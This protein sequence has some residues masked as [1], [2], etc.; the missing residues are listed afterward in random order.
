MEKLKLHSPDLSKANIDKVAELFPQCVSEA[1]DENGAIVRQIDFDLL[2]QELSGGIV[3]GP[4]ER[5]QLT[6]PGKREALLT[7]NAPI[8]KTLRPCREESVDFDTTRNLFIEGDNLDVLKLLQETYLGKVKMIYIDPPYN[9]GNDFLYNDKFSV[10]QSENDLLSSVRNDEGKQTFTTDRLTQN[11]I[12]SGRFH[13]DW[14]SMMYPRLR[15][16]KNVLR[17][18]GVMLISIDDAEVHNLRRLCDEVFGKDNFIAS[19]VWEKGRKN[20]AKLVSV[21]HEYVLVYAKSLARLKELKVIWR[22]EKPGAREI[23]EQYLQLRAEHSEGVQADRAIE[24]GLQA[25]YASLPKSHPSK[26]WSRYKRIDRHGPWRDRDISWP[27]SG[28]PR[29]DVLH[30]DTK[31]PCIVPEAGWRFSSSLEMQRQIKL[32]LVEFRADHTEPPFRK[33]HIRPIQDEIDEPDTDG[34]EESE[35]EESGDEELA[36]Q[37]RGSYFYKQSQVSVKALRKLMGAKIF[38][39]PKDLD[40]IAR[41]VEYVSSGDPEAIVMD[42]FA[43]SGTTGHSVW[44]LNANDGGRRQFILVQLPEELDPSKKDQKA[45]ANFCDKI[46]KPRTIAELTKE[47]LRRAGA[48]IKENLANRHCEEATSRRS[49]PEQAALPGSGEWIASPS[50]RNDEGGTAHND[51]KDASS[52]DI[53]F[54]VLKVDSSNMRDV[55]YLPDEARQATLLDTIDNIKPDRTP[56][57]LLFH[58]LLDW[59]VP[60]DLPIFVETIEGKTV[61]FVHKD[62]PDLA[63]CFERGVTEE[64]VKAIAARAPQRAVFRDAG[65]ASDSVKINVE[66]IFKLLSPAT[67]VK[68][69]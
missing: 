23:W 69:I 61:Y 8:A 58:V 36:T 47:R 11:S 22:E 51:G 56:E 9:T 64:L 52:L 67:E 19:M 28:G 39:N 68:V 3:E 25:W 42:F 55:F 46:G 31:L 40:E 26:K 50:A 48:Q 30:P 41:L 60:L 44:K 63:A 66:Q 33:A 5:Y 53:G 4:A 35:S 45:P 43:G 65:F 59:G 15:L 20:D 7:A 57:D 10:E 16:A 32:G 49:N 17:N 12:S 18:D 2:R 62:R 6:W 21:G 1:R 34:A 14:L 38:D 13:S 29:Y 27:G 24:I 37:V 54:R